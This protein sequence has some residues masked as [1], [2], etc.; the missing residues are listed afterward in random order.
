MV[1]NREVLISDVDAGPDGE[2]YV[3]RES[4]THQSL[5]H[6]TLAATQAY[7]NASGWQRVGSS[8]ICNGRAVDVWRNQDSGDLIAVYENVRWALWLDIE[9]FGSLYDGT[10]GKRAILALGS[11]IQDLYRIGTLVYPQERLF[12]RQLGDGFIVEPDFGDLDIMRPLAIGTAL[13]RAALMRGHCLKIGIGIGVVADVQSCYPREVMK[14]F[15]NGRAN[16]GAGLMT[17]TTVMG[18][19]LIDANKVSG[20][21]SG[22]LLLIR[23]D[24]EDTIPQGHVP[25]LSRETH[26]EVDWIHL[27]LPETARIQGV[28]GAS[29][30]SLDCESCLRSYIGKNTS[31]SDSWRDSAELLIRG[32]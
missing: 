1:T 13:Q 6:D 27:D 31:L 16:L 9:G 30:D 22:P 20:R 28:L 4:E 18:Q 26:I 32:Y 23:P 3:A 17:I 25:R 8:T 21:A 5:I 7:L 11:L 19:G 29:L 24:L 15:K 12:I 14:N 2:F 10:F